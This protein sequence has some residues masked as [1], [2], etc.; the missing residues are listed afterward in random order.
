MYLVDNDPYMNEVGFKLLLPVHDELI[1]EGP[2]EFKTEIAKKFAELMVSAASELCV[3]S[4]CDVE[5]TDRWYG[6]VIEV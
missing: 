6:K 1:G 2:E 5:V 3:P 4:I